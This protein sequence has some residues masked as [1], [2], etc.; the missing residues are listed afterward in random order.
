VRLPFA[1][2]HAAREARSS[3]RRIGLYMGTITIG[4]AALVAI[5][6]F[7]A[8]VL[9]SVTEESRALLGADVRVRSQSPFPD[10][11]VAVLDSIRAAGTPVAG[12]TS[13][14][15][16]AIAGN[17]RTRLVQVRAVDGGFPFY[18][19]IETRPAGLW[20]APADRPAVIVEPAL[21]TALD[22]AVGDSVRIGE[23]WFEI[24]GTAPSLAPEVGFQS[25]IGPRVFFNAAW[26]ASTGIV[27]FGSMIRYDAYFTTPDAWAATRFEDRYGERFRRQQVRIS[28]ADEQ[29]EFLA[30]ALDAMGRFL[31][32]VGLMA[33]LLGGLGVAS[34]IHVFVAEARPTVATLRCLGATQ[35]TAFTAY[36]V[37]AGVL[38]LLGALAGVLLGLAAQAALPVLLGGALPVSVRF[39]IEWTP[40]LSGLA[41]G[42]WVATVFALLPLLA[43]RGIAPLQALRHEV[44]PERRRPDA[45]RA[46]AWLAL[47]AS[48]LVL[49]VLQAPTRTAGLAFAGVLAATL[50][51][52]RLTAGLLIRATRRFFPR[53]ARFTVRQGVA[54]LFRPHNQTA[55][56]TMALG[57]GVFLLATLWV[58]QA[59]LLGWLR[60]ER[61]RDSPNLVAFDIQQDQV[62][63]ARAIFAQHG[64]AEPDFIPIVTARIAAI[65]GRSID[66]ILAGPEARNV[67]PWAVRREYRHTW[68]DTLTGGE[69]LIAGEWWH[70]PRADGL[71]RIS[72]EQ[73]L[74]SHLNVGLG[75]VITWNIHGVERETRIASVRTVD[76]ARFETNFFVVFEPGALD[77]AP[78]SYV[79]VAAVADDAARAAIQ[80]DLSLRHA[81]ISTVDLETIQATVRRIVGQVTLAVRFMALFS[82]AGGALV[83][84]GAL[85]AS[86]FQRVRESVLLRTLGATRAQVRRVLF[87]EY[88]VLGTLAGLAG[89]LLATGA[90][91]GLTRYVLRLDFALPA[92]ALAGGWLAVAG[93]TAAIG[94]L[95]S[96][97][98]LRRTP[99][100]VLREAGE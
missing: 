56:V 13:T 75:D 4:V 36:L 57:F 11:V 58:V 63:D 34:A 100:A 74:T 85:A 33:L 22:V 7:R 95:N 30:E 97:E 8:N 65:N 59:N 25:A 9:R 91:W 83:L 16:V 29:A 26:L 1:L 10:S 80:R 43:I 2:R 82:L 66:G 31:G 39:A 40:V 5:N 41:T 38:G 98:A 81:N 64:A 21:L 6:S 20:P 12:V 49:A 47:L 28:T 72:I 55:A 52:L 69:T 42:V 14:V 94:L 73:E 32:L 89:V 61:G 79:T 37:Q 19:R 86:R 78:A 48:M 84:L 93:L 96:R 3:A 87:T 71:P 18:G 76:W 53:R 23:R 90:G 68:R 35:R 17:G 54:S 92:A 44:E 67:Q 99:L 27:R 62:D 60:I 70:A 45:W 46:L 50:L 24:A 88:I 15:S 51:A 77:G